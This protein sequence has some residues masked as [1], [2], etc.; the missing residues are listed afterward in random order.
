MIAVVGPL[1]PS[2]PIFL[3]FFFVRRRKRKETRAGREGGSDDQ[4]HLPRT[5]LASL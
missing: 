4:D 1:Y 3:I 5:L 2:S